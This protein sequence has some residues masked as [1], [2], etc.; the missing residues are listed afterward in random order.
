MFTMRHN[1]EYVWTW[2]GTFF[3]YLQDDNLRSYTGRHVGYI[4]GHTVF[5]LNGHYL[6]EIVNGRLLVND[7][8][9]TLWAVPLPQLPKHA[10]LPKLADLEGYGVYRGYEDFP[11][12]EAFEIQG[13]RSAA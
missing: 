9:K 8:R 2:G 12:P 4:T 13:L 1:L 3:G 10:A 6:G 11:A 5:G 7:T